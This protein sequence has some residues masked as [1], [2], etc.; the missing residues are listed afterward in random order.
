MVLTH[1]VYCHPLLHT[2]HHAHRCDYLIG[3]PSAPSVTTSPARDLESLVFSIT[4]PVYAYECVLRYTISTT[5]ND[6]MVIN[7]FSVT[8]SQ[9][10]EIE[11]MVMGTYNVCVYTYNFTALPVTRDG[12]GQRSRVFIQ[13]QVSLGTG[14]I[15]VAESA[16]FLYFLLVI[17]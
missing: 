10:R 5:T 8:A 13:A 6:N 12:F 17:F 2:S 11:T 14:S 16:Q 4:P 15:P 7:D 3:S 1:T 9:T